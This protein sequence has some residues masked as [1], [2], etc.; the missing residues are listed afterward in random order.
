VRERNDHLVW[1]AT[2]SRAPARDGQTVP[3]P[4]WGYRTSVICTISSLFRVRVG[5]GAT[6]AVQHVLG[7]VL[8]SGRL[9]VR[10]ALATV[11]WVVG[12]VVGLSAITWCY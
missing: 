8:D 10:C 3:C 4:V 12:C 11:Y 5:D 7:G 9:L 6:H 1:S 2:S